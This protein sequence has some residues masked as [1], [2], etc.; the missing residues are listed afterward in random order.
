M[1][2]GKH[3]IAAIDGLDGKVKWMTELRNTSRCQGSPV[4]GDVDGDGDS[5]IIVVSGQRVF[6]ITAIDGS[7]EWRVDVGPGVDREWSDMITPVLLWNES[8]VRCDI[9]YADPYGNV[10]KIDGVDGRVIKRTVLRELIDSQVVIGSP[11]LEF[12]LTES[13]DV[14]ILI[15]IK[16]SYNGAMC[17]LDPDLD[18]IWWERFSTYRPLGTPAVDTSVHGLPRIVFNSWEYY[19]NEDRIVV[20]DALN[21]QELWNRSLAFSGMGDERGMTIIDDVD[22]N[23]E[24]E[25][26]LMNSPKDTV[27]V[28]D[29]NGTLEW[30]MKTKFWGIWAICDIDADHIIEIL[31]SSL[32]GVACVSGLDGTSK[33]SMDL[34]DT[35]NDPI[36]V[37]DIDGDNKIELVAGSFHGTV[38]SVKGSANENFVPL[39]TLD[40]P[41]NGSVV[42]EWVTISGSVLDLDDNGDNITIEFML[43]DGEWKTLGT[44]NEF[45]IKFMM[46]QTAKTKCILCVRAADGEDTSNVIVRELTQGRSDS[47]LQSSIPYLILLLVLIVSILVYLYSRQ[48]RNA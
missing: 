39:L 41:S 17:V 23:G 18:L 45:E 33:W 8:A 37:S 31:A 30:S 12:K 32:T 26:I 21:G 22:L 25:Y 35:L 46:E 20:L 43:D 9:V 47:I 10:S 6:S 14:S 3:I 11:L 28:F 27:Y 16:F 2:D 48:I 15:T 29:R 13:D 7:V 5:E 1:G 19:H 44:G 34:G 40:S 42:A 38:T 4:V 36:L 24:P